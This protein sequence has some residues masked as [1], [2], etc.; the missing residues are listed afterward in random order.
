MNF[1]LVHAHVVL[2][3]FGK[4]LVLDASGII[5]EYGPSVLFK[6]IIP[7]FVGYGIEGALKFGVYE[8]LKPAFISIFSFENLTISSLFASIIS[9]SMA[10]IV[11]CPIE[12]SKVETIL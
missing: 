3:K 5:Q 8:A 7:T 4:G 2:K 1:K 6:G 12:V 9:G 11:L 10:S